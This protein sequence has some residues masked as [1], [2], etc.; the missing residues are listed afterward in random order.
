[1]DMTTIEKNKIMERKN[2]IKSPLQ[3][4]EGRIA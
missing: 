1:M 2:S 3:N 4:L